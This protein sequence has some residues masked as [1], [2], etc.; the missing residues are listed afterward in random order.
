MPLS[1][2]LNELS[3]G[4]EAGPREVDQAMDG[5]IGTLRHIK[6]EW[7]QD[8]TLVTQSPLN[9]AELAQ[10]YVYQQWRNHSPRNREQH[11]YLLALRNKH[12]VREVLPTTH[13]P[14]AVEYRHR[15][16]L[17]EGIAAAHL[18]NGMAISLPVEREWG[19]CWVEL[20][21]LCLAEDELEESREPVRHC[22]CPAE[23]DEHQAW[24]RAPVPTTA[25]R[26]AALGYARRI[27]PQRVPF[28]S[29]GQDAYSNGKEYITP[30]VDGHNV[31][32]GWKRFD[33]SGARTGTY[34]A[35]LR[36]VK[37]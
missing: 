21:I 26:A 13:D 10:G 1:L 9:K 2:F 19:C 33:R 27:P 18:T 4:S 34:D 11:R 31:T 7:Q 23:A 16:R 22:S 35:S 12:P 25:Q 29:H 17:V 24:G 28:D 15:G 20:E 37:E 32:D 14:A 8:I 6:K 3:C 5:F 36:Y 30:D